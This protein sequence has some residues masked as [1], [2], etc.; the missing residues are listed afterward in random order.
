MG[1]TQSTT[2]G[3]R[4]EEGPLPEG[5]RGHGEA[6]EECLLSV[7]LEA[8]PPSEGPEREPECPADLRSATLW[9]LDNESIERQEKRLLGHTQGAA[10]YATQLGGVDMV[11][12]L[13]LGPGRTFV[14]AALL[15]RLDGRAGAP[16]LLGYGGERPMLLLEALPGRSFLSL[17]QDED[18]PLSLLLKVVELVAQ[19]L[20]EMHALG[21]VHND[22]AVPNV[23]V[24][25]ADDYQ[26]L[27]ARLAEFTLACPSG[28]SLGMDA[29]PAACPCVA[30]EV[31]RGGA[32]TPAA[33]VF[34]LGVLLQELS[35]VKADAQE[36]PLQ[37][38]EAAQLAT[39]EEPQARPDLAV[40]EELLHEAVLWQKKKEK[41]KKNKK[42]RMQKA[43]IAH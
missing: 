24:R 19:R 14:E 37:A 15:L 10:L 36:L 7:V 35:R 39:Q 20:R 12:K 25:V 4:P 40:V 33:D 6:Q 26:L 38:K 21:V 41:R 29:E 34:S 3:R 28:H 13:M 8:A 31:A 11:M 42:T 23:V 22:V 27:E 2:T 16:R 32:S 30:P 18:A 17:L 43:K 1:N 9:L 5:P